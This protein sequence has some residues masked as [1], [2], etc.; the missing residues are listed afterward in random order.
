MASI[1]HPLNPDKSEIR[2]LTISPGTD[3]DDLRCS[4]EVRSLLSNP[5]FEALSYV[6]GDATIK[7]KIILENAPYE[8]TSSL[9]SA[10]Y[11]LRQPSLPRIVWVDALCINQCDTSEKNYQIPLMGNIYKSAS[12]VIAWLG[13]GSPELDYFA[14]WTNVYFS[15][16]HK[17]RS[18]RWIKMKLWSKISR[19]GEKNEDNHNYRLFLGQEAFEGHIYFRRMWTFQEFILPELRPMFLTDKSA[20]RIDYYNADTS[21]LRFRAVKIF[22]RREEDIDLDLLPAWKA[23]DLGN[24]GSGVAD[25][26]YLDL[27]LSGDSRSVTGLPLPSLLSITAHRECSDPRDKIFAL[28]P[29][30]KEKNPEFPPPDYAKPSE[31]VL[32]EAMT[33]I[34]NGDWNWALSEAM[35]FWPLRASRLIDNQYPSWL[36]DLSS[37]NPYSMISNWAS[38]KIARGEKRSANLSKDSK[39][40]DLEAQIIGECTVLHRFA[41]DAGTICNQISALLGLIT[42]SSISIM[43][44]STELR[45]KENLQGRL[46]YACHNHDMGR[47]TYDIPQLVFMYTSFAKELTSENWAE[48]PSYESREPQFLFVKEFTQNI[49]HLANKCLFETET[50]LFGI[51]P[52]ELEDGDLIV[53]SSC[54]PVPFALR[55]LE[56]SLQERECNALH[57]GWAFIDGLFGETKHGEVLEEIDKQTPIHLSLQ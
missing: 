15:R 48:L 39:T 20:F 57:A 17:F 36:P 4:L 43:S 49:Q 44:T 9:R 53:T 18:R 13:N 26:H 19:K 11:R 29:L 28:Y 25:K 2:L 3:Q 51:G 5:K 6:W 21:T 12:L 38:Y 45:I 34:I 1:F 40:L 22:Y 16:F 42:D 31:Q 32:W 50:G 27:M 14:S 56:S 41:N 52:P 30:F 37:R 46:A 23:T 24:I 54:F 7:H 47:T 10:L 33:Y 35:A 55:Q 8:I